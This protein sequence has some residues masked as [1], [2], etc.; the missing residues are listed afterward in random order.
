LG[1]F[2]ITHGC[3]HS[4]PEKIQRQPGGQASIDEVLKVQHDLQLVL[5]QPGQEKHYP[6]QH[7]PT[8]TSYCGPHLMGKL[9][10]IHAIRE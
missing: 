2:G 4:E 6:T 10:A 9:M 3:A 7:R 5:L 8:I 1:T